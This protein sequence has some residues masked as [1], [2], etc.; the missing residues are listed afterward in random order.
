MMKMGGVKRPR[1]E[2][3]V[4]G[5]ILGS[6]IAWM[7]LLGLS[8][9]NPDLVSATALTFIVYMGD[10][11]LVTCLVAGRASHGHVMIGLK[12]GVAIWILNML[13]LFLS[14]GTS[15]IS[16]GVLLFLGSFLLGGVIGGFLSRR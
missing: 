12:M 8:L 16:R 6:S 4:A 15:G 14:L 1:I 10:S 13:L 11:A 9:F 2:D 3:Y 7:W 5:A